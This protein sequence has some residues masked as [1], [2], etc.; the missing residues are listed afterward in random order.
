MW[1]IKRL[2]IIKERTTLIAIAIYEQYI[3]TAHW[4]E[5]LMALDNI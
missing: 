2:E 5:A 1:I 4:L 3:F